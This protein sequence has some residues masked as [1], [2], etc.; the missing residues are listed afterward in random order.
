ML[1]C[2]HEYLIV[3]VFACLLMHLPILELA[4]ARAIVHS[5][6]L[7]TML[8]C[9][10]PTDDALFLI[11]WEVCMMIVNA[12]HFYGQRISELC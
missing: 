3:E 1:P 11:Y 5:S 2:H 10:L 6:T 12:L 7:A 8:A 9:L 4:L